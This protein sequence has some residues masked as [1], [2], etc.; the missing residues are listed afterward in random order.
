MS[1]QDDEKN[2]AQPALQRVR[3]ER[4]PLAAQWDPVWQLEN[5]MGTNPLWLTEELLQHL[6]L[7]AEQRVLDLGCGKGMSSMFL[8]KE[9]RVNVWATDLWTD[10]DE[11]W[12]HA[13][14]LGLDNFVCPIQ[15]E[16]HT[17]P[18]AH[19]FFDAVVC[20]DAW[21]L[22]G[23][24][25][26]FVGNIA[27]YVTPGGY[28]AMIGPGLRSEFENGLPSHIVP[29]WQQEFWS[30]HSPEW[31]RDLWQ[32]EPNLDVV[33]AE[34]VPDGWKLWLEWEEIARDAGY[35]FVADDIELLRADAG[36][37]LGLVCVVA[38]VGAGNTTAAT[39]PSGD[40]G[41]E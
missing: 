14:A 8:A 28:I 35:S 31:W 19:G 21:H 11:T 41:R 38:E 40:T 15:A 18:F 39:N 20:V 17:L 29:F 33:H 6:P 24:G 2:Q 37:H 34:L 9:R 23:L 12:R 26:G 22:F 16:A 5:M 1:Q 32:S 36:Q 30:L 13:R 27:E 7:Q 3:N 4:Y 10:P 25:Q